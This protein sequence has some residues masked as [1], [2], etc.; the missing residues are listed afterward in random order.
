[1]ALV[2]MDGFDHYA[3]ADLAKKG[4][5]VTGNPVIHITAGRRGT[6]A[7]NSGASNSYWISRTLLV[8]YPTL[9]AGFAFSPNGTFP[10]GTSAR[11]LEFMDGSTTQCS[12]WLN[13]D[14]TLIATRATTIIGQTTAVIPSSGFTYIEAKFTFHPTAGTVDLRMNGLSVLSL[15]G[16]NTRNSANSFANRVLLGQYASSQSNSFYDDFYLCDSSGAVNN[17]FLGDVRVDTLF[18]N[19]DGFYSQFTPSTGTSH[20]ACV[21][22]TLPLT[23]D[24]VSGGTIGFKDSY[25]LTDLTGAAS[26]LG[27]QV[28]ALMY[29]D[30]AGFRQG[31]NL[32]RSGST[33]LQSATVTVSTSPQ[34]SISVHETDPATGAA[35]TQSAVNAMEAGV[36][37][38]G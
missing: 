21:D 36:V 32:I 31:A 38:I 37:V 13:F 25:A 18:P 16:L 29:K 34:Y 10:V 14:G 24:F 3:T 4:W 12:V 2:F 11:I 19:A 8:N 35:W 28:N 33:D 1:M 23:S 20:F 22:E 30:D 6:G 27:V 26:V 5:N 7:F 9:I 17:T 15:S